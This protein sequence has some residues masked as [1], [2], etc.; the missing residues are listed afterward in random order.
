[1]WKALTNGDRCVR[2]S[3][4]AGPHSIKTEPG[5]IQSCFGVEVRRCKGGLLKW[6]ESTGNR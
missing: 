2:T 3:K 1:M 5:Q 6:V 4:S